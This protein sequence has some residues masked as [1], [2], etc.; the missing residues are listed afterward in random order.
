MLFTSLITI[1]TLINTLAQGYTCEKQNSLYKVVRVTTKEGKNCEKGPGRKSV[2]RFHDFSFLNFEF[3]RI[4]FR[5]PPY[6]I[7]N[8]INYDDR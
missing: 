4:A 8:S 1:L 6:H 5:I 7:E 2:G 3:Q